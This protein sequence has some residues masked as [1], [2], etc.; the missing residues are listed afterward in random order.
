MKNIK[1]MITS[2]IAGLTAAAALAVTA[3][4]A[5]RSTSEANMV[6]SATAET[7]IHGTSLATI[8]TMF[9]EVRTETGSRVR[10]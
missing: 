6:I 10:V 3:S 5:E 8:S 4:A 1:K 9:C 7:E 2:A